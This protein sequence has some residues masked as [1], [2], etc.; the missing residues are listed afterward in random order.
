MQVENI[1]NVNWNE[2]QFD[3]QTRLKGEPVEGIDQLCFTPGAPRLI[4]TS[5][6]YYF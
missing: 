4:K 1:F 2:A 6:S 3:T 5:I